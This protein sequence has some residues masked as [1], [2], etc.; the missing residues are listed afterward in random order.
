MTGSEKFSL[1]QRNKK[2]IQDMGISIEINHNKSIQ[3]NSDNFTALWEKNSF[4][5]F[6]NTNVRVLNMNQKQWDEY[7][8]EVDNFN[9]AI[10]RVNS[11]MK[12][13]VFEI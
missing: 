4:K 9:R 7:Y 8:T 1:I 10:F 6:N 3:I 13:V 2:V 12:E 5:I 11:I